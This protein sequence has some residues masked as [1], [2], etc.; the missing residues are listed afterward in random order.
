MHSA[1]AGSAPLLPGTLGQRRGLFIPTFE[2]R[3]SIHENGDFRYQVSRA[4]L[5]IVFLIG[6]G[7]ALSATQKS[8]SPVDKVS[9]TRQTWHQEGKLLIADVTLRNNNAFSVKQVIVTCEVLGDRGRPKDTRGSAV[10]EVLP[11]GEKTISGLEFPIV[12][13]TAQGGGCRVLSAVRN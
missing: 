1:N 8:V 10:R 2:R 13:T 7:P 3:R 12:A 6:F 5:V 11:P 9:F 4:I